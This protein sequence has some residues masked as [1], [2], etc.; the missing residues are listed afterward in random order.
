MKEVERK[1][2]TE[3]GVICGHQLEREGVERRKPQILDICI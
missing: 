2:E 3:G 1:N